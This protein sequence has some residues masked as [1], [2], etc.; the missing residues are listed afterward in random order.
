MKKIAL[1]LMLVVAAAMF[2][3]SAQAQAYLQ[4]PKYGNSPEER[5]KNVEILNYFNDAYNNK[6]FNTAAGYLQQLMVGAPKASQ[7]MYIHGT[8]IYRT[9]LSKEKDPAARTL[10]LDSLMHIYD[11]RIKNFGSHATRGEVYLLGLKFRDYMANNPDNSD[12]LEE[13]FEA[14]K[15][16]DPAKMDPALVNLYFNMIVEGYKNDAVGT[17]E[18]LSTYDELSAIF[19]VSASPK[20]AA[21]KETF[22]NLFVSS[23]AASCENLEKVFGPA[24]EETPT[25]KDLLGK[26][27]NLLT[28][29][30][31]HTPFLTSVGEKFYAVEPSSQVALSLAT[32]YENESNF[33]KA[34]YYLNEA[35]NNETLPGVKANLC[36]RLAG[37]AIQDQRPKDAA[38]FAKRAIEFDPESGLAYFILANAYAAG[39]NG[40]SGFNRQA[41]YWLVVDTY[42]KARELLAHDQAQVDVINAQINSLAGGYP[43]QEECF[44]RGLESGSGYTVSC[45]WLSGRTTVRTNR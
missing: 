13:L 32:S 33:E 6:D 14:A 5:Q 45:G 21:E 25:D 24:I 28:I 43:S 36:L 2:T 26:V 44:F 27:F 20:A 42:Q 18:L 1:N 34:A 4:D 30:N 22:D 38:E 15:S 7:N 16:V 35:L 39:A 17:D 23:G 12:R 8:T 11:V 9:K 10:L 41:A 37:T 19:E 29:N 40:C 3:L 31:C